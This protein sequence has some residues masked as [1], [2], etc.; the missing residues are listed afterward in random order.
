M[1]ARKR[2]LLILGSGVTIILSVIIIIIL[3]LYTIY[4]TPLMD[5]IWPEACGSHYLGKG[6]YIMEGDV[7]SNR[8]IVK[9]TIISGRACYGGDEIFPDVCG[10]ETINITSVEE[11]KTYVLVTICNESVDSTYLY[12]IE[13]SK[14]SDTTNIQTIQ[15]NYVSLVSSY[16]CSPPTPDS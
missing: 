6:L 15:K 2:I 13:L 16:K 11:H 10:S 12:R 9:G 5:W 14:I 1:L 4:C 8:T 7:F 3:S